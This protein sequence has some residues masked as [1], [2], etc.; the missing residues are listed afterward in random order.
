[1]DLGPPPPIFSSRTGGLGNVLTFSLPVY[2][3]IFISI[4]ALF[5][6]E[7]PDSQ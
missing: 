5:L 1:V 7:G 6:V 3:L 2:K 4:H